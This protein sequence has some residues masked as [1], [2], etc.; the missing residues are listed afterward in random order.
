MVF[1]APCGLYIWLEGSWCCR[2]IRFATKVDA[3]NELAKKVGGLMT[4]ST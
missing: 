1:M 3:F 2:R 4:T